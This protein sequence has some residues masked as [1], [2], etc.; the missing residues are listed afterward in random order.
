[1]MYLR[2]LG[3][4]R[5]D[6]QTMSLFRQAADKGYALAMANLGNLYERGRGVTKDK[7]QAVEWYQKAAEKGE[8]KAKAALKR[9]GEA[10]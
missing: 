6:S 1:M 7:A 5:D 3:M 10:E 2:G 4:P 8:Q 9:L